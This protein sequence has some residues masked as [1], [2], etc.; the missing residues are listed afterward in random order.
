MQDQ[1]FRQ[2][3]F[4]Y[5]S[6]ALWLA[7]LL[8][9]SISFSFSNQIISS[10]I[11]RFCRPT[12]QLLTRQILEM[13]MLVIKSPLIAVNVDK[14]T[15]SVCEFSI[16]DSQSHYYLPSA[17]QSDIKMPIRN[18]MKQ[19]QWPVYWPGPIKHF[20][21]ISN[22]FRLSCVCVC[23]KIFAQ[24]CAAS[25]APGRVG[26]QA[27]RTQISRTK[28]DLIHSNNEHNHCRDDNHRILNTFRWSCWRT[29]EIAQCHVQSVRLQV[30]FAIFF[31]RAIRCGPTVVVVR[32]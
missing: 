9:F 31:L 19:Q 4:S 28:L 1:H 12:H 18:V 10:R 6:L 30:F 23:G 5:A 14:Q 20:E 27:K 17:S 21:W 2:S 32:S 3:N 25:Q 8:H 13:K 29:S 15:N 11:N 24:R 26:S 7:S 16:D 22:A